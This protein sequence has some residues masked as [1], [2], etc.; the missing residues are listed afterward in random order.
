[1][2]NKLYKSPWSVFW[3]T[4]RAA[5]Q[6]ARGVRVINKMKQPIVTIFGGSKVEKGS[7]YAQ[8]A[9]DLAKQ[10]AAHDISVLTGGGPGIMEFANCGA[11]A[12][13]KKEANDI[14]SLGIRVKGVDDE[15]ST[16][17]GKFLCVDSFGIRKLLL[18]RSSLGFVLFPGGIGTCDELFEVLTYMKHNKVPRF[19]I[20]LFGKEYWQQI[21]DWYV[22]TAVEQ[23]LIEQE[24]KDFLFVTDDIALIYQLLAERL[25]THI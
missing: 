3:S 12:G 6:L 10:L 11:A 23:G 21:V 9:H 4:V 15:F 14:F 17:C 19:T 2:D 22:H 5:F 7:F 25:Q 1:M 24:Y 20:L 16:T 18:M 8:K 13:H